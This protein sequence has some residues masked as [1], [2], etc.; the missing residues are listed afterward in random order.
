[1]PWGGHSLCG[2]PA[3]YLPPGTV[4]QWPSC[5]L[6]MADRVKG[7]DPK[8][9]QEGDDSDPGLASRRES[10][11]TAKDKKVLSYQRGGTREHRRRGAIA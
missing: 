10:S 9:D 2:R 5:H 3:G 1:M 11:L 6:T 8:T 7:G 4:G